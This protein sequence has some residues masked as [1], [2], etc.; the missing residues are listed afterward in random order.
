MSE[1]LGPQFT[2]N[3]KCKQCF[4]WA[5]KGPQQLPTFNSDVDPTMGAGT[6]TIRL[7]GVPTPTPTS[8]FSSFGSGI[9]GFGL[10]AFG[11][12]LPSSHHHHRLINIKKPHKHLQRH[13][14]RLLLLPG[15]A[16]LGSSRLS[17]LLPFL[18][19]HTYIFFW[20][21]HAA[22][23]FSGHGSYVP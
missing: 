14:P 15:F 16:W 17:T 6:Q 19:I 9:L 21:R 7:V 3:C 11:F 5:P 12:R 23:L 13:R 8:C 18:Y 20:I 10:S 2:V 4:L 22:A 1:K